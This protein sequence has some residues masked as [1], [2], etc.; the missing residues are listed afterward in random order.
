MD[1]VGK[2]RAN[3]LPRKKHEVESKS[4]TSSPCTIG[5]KVAVD[6]VKFGKVRFIGTT[7]FATGEWIGVELE[8]PSG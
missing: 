7:K 6:G 4:L 1:D 3:T 8:Q 5:E 2:A